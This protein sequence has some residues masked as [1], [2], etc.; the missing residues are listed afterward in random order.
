MLGLRIS[1]ILKMKF[2][3]PLFLLAASA[4]IN[5]AQLE[6]QNCFI[7]WD[8]VPYDVDPLPLRTSFYYP[9]QAMTELAI[10]CDTGLSCCLCDSFLP[11]IERGLYTY[12][13]TARLHSLNSG[14]GP[15]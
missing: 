2:S 7:T 9:G 11:F 5:A 10:A 4:T 12:S 14:N 15:V 8:G 3:F 6:G 1:L 13:P